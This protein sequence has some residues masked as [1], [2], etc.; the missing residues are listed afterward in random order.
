MHKMKIPEDRVPLSIQEFGSAGG[1]SV[2]LTL[3]QGNLTRPADRSLRL[4]LVG[5]GVGLSW[6]SA[7]ISLAPDAVLNHVVVS[8]PYVS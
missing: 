5:Y 1:P 8:E 6:G 3:T 2:A 7:L 4:L